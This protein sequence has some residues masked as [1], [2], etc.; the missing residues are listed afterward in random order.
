VNLIGMEVVPSKRRIGPRKE[1]SPVK[2]L[3]EQAGV[4]EVRI[5]SSV[6]GFL[7][8]RETTEREGEW[9]C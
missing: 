2:P 7:K 5:G 9:V 4:S 6:R 3:E 1:S 8:A